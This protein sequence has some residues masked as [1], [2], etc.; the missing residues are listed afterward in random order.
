MSKLMISQNGFTGVLSS[1]GYCYVR[2]I[3]DGKGEEPKFIAEAR[4]SNGNFEFIPGIKYSYDIDGLIPDD[5]SKTAAKRFERWL[6]KV[7]P[8]MYRQKKPSTVFGVLQTGLGP[9]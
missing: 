8:E 4:F 3:W 2:P 6:K 5:W 1:H 7:C 9:K